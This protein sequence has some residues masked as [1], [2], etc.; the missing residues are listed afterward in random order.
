ME[1]QVKPRRKHAICTVALCCAFL[2][3]CGYFPTRG[4]TAGADARIW[5]VLREY[6][7][8]HRP[9]HDTLDAHPDFSHREVRRSALPET[10]LY[11][12]TYAVPAM[13]HATVV[14]VGAE[15]RSGVTI[16]EGMD[17]WARLRA[18][19]DWQP[20][21]GEEAIRGC[22]EFILSTHPERSTRGTLQLYSA[23]NPE[24]GAAILIL[25]EQIRAFAREPSAV[26]MPTG[27]RVE[28]T[29]L[30]K[31]RTVR[32]ECLLGQRGSMDSYVVRDSVAGP[33]LPAR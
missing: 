29:V 2:A 27:W 20:G 17:D 12:G 33:G 24:L 9:L 15:H 28:L 31:G 25:P 23:R 8:D 1:L 7:R 14:V 4:P 19:S 11:W 32:Y 26:R 10:R 18:V 6:L 13:G 5:E 16:I 30:A 3:A 21:S 22:T